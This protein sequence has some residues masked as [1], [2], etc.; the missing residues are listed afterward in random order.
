MISLLLLWF[1]SS[2]VGVCLTDVTV[3]L[4]LMLRSQHCEPCNEF[5]HQ[6]HLRQP[7]VPNKRVHQGLSEVLMWPCHEG[8][9]TESEVTLLL[10]SPFRFA[11]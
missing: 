2:Q 3:F 9:L 11:R 5:L 8:T 6:G 10:T 1:L 4:V 7:P